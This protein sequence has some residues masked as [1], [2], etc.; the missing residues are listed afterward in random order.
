MEASDTVLEQLPTN[1]VDVLAEFFSI[2]RPD[3]KGDPRAGDCGRRLACAAAL[4]T[5]AE[6]ELP[7]DYELARQSADQKFRDEAAARARRRYRALQFA[8]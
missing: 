8:A 3:P 7:I 5:W 4:R 1:E 2:G 6:K